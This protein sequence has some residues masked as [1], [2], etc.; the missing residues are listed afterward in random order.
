MSP[1]TTPLEHKSSSPCIDSS[2]VMPY[3]RFMWRAAQDEQNTAHFGARAATVSLF[4]HRGLIVSL[5]NV[6]A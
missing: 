2:P 1:P 6:Q 3:G 5:S 4:I